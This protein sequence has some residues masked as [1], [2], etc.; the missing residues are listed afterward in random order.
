[1]RVVPFACFLLNYR[2]DGA[3]V[4]MWFG[5]PGWGQPMSLAGVAPVI[6]PGG[7]LEKARRWNKTVCAVLPKRRRP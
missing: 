7:L 3:P 1:M 5:W 6:A 2:S 4:D